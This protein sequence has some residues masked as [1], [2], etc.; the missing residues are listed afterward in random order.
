MEYDPYDYEID[1]NPYPI[2]ASLRENQP[3][4]FNEKLVIG[5]RPA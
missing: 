3:L 5:L 4:Y 1:K 2:Y